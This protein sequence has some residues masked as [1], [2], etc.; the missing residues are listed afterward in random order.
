M[1]RF[2]TGDTAGFGSSHEQEA[3]NRGLAYMPLLQTQTESIFT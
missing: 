1:D 3:L 2:K